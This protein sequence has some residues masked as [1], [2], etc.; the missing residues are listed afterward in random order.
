MQ[1][2]IH[3]IAPLSA[4]QR[5]EPDRA[6]GWSVKDVLAHLTWWDQ[7]LL[8]T[9]PSLPQS[10][11][12]ARPA[13]FEQIP[14]ATGWANEMNARVYA[15]YRQRDLADI[16]I[17]FDLPRQHL[18]QRVRVLSIDDLFNP[19]GLSAQIGHAVAPI[20][21]GIYEHYEEHAQALEARRYE[22]Q[23]R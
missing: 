20:V 17:E 9:L 22:S 23:G 11:P 2:V 10:E 14:S 19:D 8:A 12:P 5:Q 7:W 13:L 15:Y 3:A 16:Q 4:A 1:R 18:L 21:L 6:G